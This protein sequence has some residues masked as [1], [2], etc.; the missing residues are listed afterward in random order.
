MAGAGVVF[1]GIPSISGQMSFRFETNL[2]V[3]AN[4]KLRIGYPRSITVNCEGAFLHKVGL[5]G[6]IRCTNF[7]RL[8]YFEIALPRPLPPGRQGVAV[9]ATPPNAIDEDDGSS[10]YIMVIDSDELGG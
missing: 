2:K 3:E 4:G 9:T 6:D 7:P 10:F 1:P 8:G 5:E